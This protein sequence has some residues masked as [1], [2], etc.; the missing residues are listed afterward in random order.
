MGDFTGDG[1]V[2][3]FDLNVLAA[4]W[5]AGV[6]AEAAQ[7]AGPFFFA[8]NPTNANTESTAAVATSSESTQRART[9]ASVASLSVKNIHTT[10]TAIAIE[11]PT[12]TL[13]TP[14]PPAKS[15]LTGLLT[16]TDRTVVK[17]WF[18]LYAR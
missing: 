6:S 13:K 14:T 2:D 1:K 11:P 17:F 3:A 4:N 18:S 16:P 10:R 8:P 15:H 12:R 9:I 5:Q 7:L